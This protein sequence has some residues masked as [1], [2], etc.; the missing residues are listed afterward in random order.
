MEIEDADRTETGGSYEQYGE[1]TRKASS[2]GPKRDQQWKG[3]LRIIATVA[4]MLGLASLVPL[5]WNMIEA[6]AEARK[7][8]VRAQTETS[9]YFYRQVSLIRATCPSMNAQVRRMLSKGRLT[10]KD[11]YV[12]RSELNDRH[13]Q[14]LVDKGRHDGR[15][16]VG[17]P[18]GPEPVR[19][20][21]YEPDP[22]DDESAILPWEYVSRQDDL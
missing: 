18:S 21:K 13:D 11:V 8:D 4:L 12:L 14:Y 15:R 9:G 20:S 19:C 7:W 17:L 16:V 3:T 22:Y 10:V 6:R 2:P 1:R 5:S